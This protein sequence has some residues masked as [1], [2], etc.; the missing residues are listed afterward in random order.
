MSEQELIEIGF[1]KEGVIGESGY[2]YFYD[3]KDIEGPATLISDCNDEVENDNWY[4]YAWDIHEA[5]KM[6]DIYDVK[7]YIEVL[8]KNI[9]E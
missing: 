7:T 9:E 4:V 8:E 3:I 5:F 2:Y 6:N 1:I